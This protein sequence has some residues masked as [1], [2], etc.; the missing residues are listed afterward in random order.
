MSAIFVFTTKT[1]QPRPHVFS[2]KGVLTCKKTA[3]L[4]SS[5]RWWNAN[6]F[7]IWSSVAGYGE[8]WVCVCLN[9]AEISVRFRNLGGQN[10]AEI[11]LGYLNVGGQ[12]SAEISAAKILPRIS[13]RFLNLGCQNQTDFPYMLQILEFFTENDFW[14]LWLF[15]TR[16][17]RKA[18]NQFPCFTGHT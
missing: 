4:T 3:L 2:V 12:N 1:T 7:Q 15:H 16:K 17:A 5:I 11:S 6:I 9:L 10:P 18:K 14:L 8:L 13:Q